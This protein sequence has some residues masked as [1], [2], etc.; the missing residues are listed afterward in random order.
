MTCQIVDGDRFPAQLGIAAPYV[1]YFPID[2]STEDP[3]YIATTSE[4][5]GELGYTEWL[6][7]GGSAP[8]PLTYSLDS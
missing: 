1:V 5:L 4:K 6:E 8:P 2:P 7:D 3:T